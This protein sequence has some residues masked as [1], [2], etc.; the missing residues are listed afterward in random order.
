MTMEQ[1]EKTAQTIRNTCT[2]K[3]HADPGEL[4]R[5]KNRNL[6]FIFSLMFIT[7]RNIMH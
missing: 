2:S 6:M 5:Y 4:M 7:I 1:I 3:S